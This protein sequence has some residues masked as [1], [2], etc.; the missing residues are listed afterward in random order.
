MAGATACRVGSQADASSPR[1][2]DQPHRGHWIGEGKIVV[3]EPGV[4]TNEALRNF[5]REHG[6]ELD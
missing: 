3:D 2:Q 6:T 4:V 1:T 5:Y